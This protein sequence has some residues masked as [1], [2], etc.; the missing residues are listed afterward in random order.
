MENGVQELLVKVNIVL[1]AHLEK[2]HT[3]ED[4][5]TV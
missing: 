3:L 4:W 5:Q 2:I 1:I